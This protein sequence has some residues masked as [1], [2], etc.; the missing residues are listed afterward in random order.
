[1][2]IY[3]DNEK[4]KPLYAQLIANPDNP[5][6]VRTVNAPVFHKF[7]LMNVMRGNKYCPLY[8]TLESIISMQPNGKG[9]EVTLT[10]GKSHQVTESIQTI[11]AMCDEHEIH[12]EQLDPTPDEQWLEAQM[13]EKIV[14]S[15]TT[16][17]FPNS[18]PKSLLEQLK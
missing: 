9:T 6:L 7:T 3:I 4:T 16:G 18:T 14:H 12:L 17:A 10:T 8:L 15:R 13:R 2:E 1:M 5:L 11:L